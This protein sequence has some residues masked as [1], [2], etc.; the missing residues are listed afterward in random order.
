MSNIDL[1]Q[2]L[3]H[4]WQQGVEFWLE[5]DQLRFRGNKNL[6]SGDTLSL[7]RDNKPAITEIIKNNPQAYLGFPLSHGQRGIYLMQNLAPDSAAYNLTCLLQLDK[8]LNLT[9]LQNSL[10]FL[11][12][13]HAP[14]RMSIQTLDGYLAQ[15]VSYSLPSILT[16]TEVDKLDAEQLQQWV[17]E[18][19]DKAFNLA[20]EPLIRAR[21]LC[22]RDDH[23][24]RLLLVAHHIIADFWAM[25]LLVKELTAIYQ[26]GLTDS[27]P[28]LPDI[29]K[30]YKDFV[31]HERQWLDSEQGLAAKNYWNTKLQPLPATLELPTDYKRPQQQS[32][33]GTEFR[34]ELGTALTAQL[35]E[36][37][38][39]A[40]VTPF[41]WVLSVFQTLLH[42]YTGEDRI[43]VGSPMAC[44][45]QHDFQLLAGH[46][47]NPVIVLS[48]FG[49][50]TVFKEL[51]YDNKDQ[52][53]QAMK[54]QEYPL[55]CLMEDLQPHRDNPT[56][57]LFNAVLSWN[58]LN[59]TT[60][61][62]DFAPRQLVQEI[63]L[64]EQ[65]GAIYDLVLTGYD[66]GSNIELSWRFNTDLFKPGTI[67]RLSNH[68]L[69][70]L[71]ITCSNSNC[72]IG[73]LDFRTQQEK[74]FIVSLNDTHRD[75]ATH[76]S[77]AKLFRHTA[78]QYP[79]Y[80]ALKDGEKH[81]TYTE[82]ETRSNQLA[83]YLTSQGL[84]PR[85]HI[86]LCLYR[87]QDMLIAI[88]A[89]L[90]M[91]CTYIPIDTSYPNDRIAYMAMQSEAPLLI[92]SKTLT[93]KLSELAE[94]APHTAIQH[95]EDIHSVLDQY[96]TEFALYQDG[97]CDEDD[98]ACVLYTSGSTG[99]PKGVK[100]PHR[101]IIRLCT[102]T[103]LFTFK[104]ADKFC[105][106]SNI[107]FDATNIEIWGSFLNGGCLLKID[108]DTLLN[109]QRFS[110]FIERENPQA[111]L[112]TTAL[113]NVFISYKPDMFK[114]FNFIFV[115]GEALDI[116]PVRRCVEHGK[117]QHLLNIYGPTENGTIS[118]IY[119]IFDANIVDIPIGK[120]ISN[121][122]V[123]VHD[124]YGIPTPFN[125]QGEVFVGGE[126]I[127]TGY[128]KQPDL[129]AE[130]FTADPYRGKG[131]LYATG[132]LGYFREDGEL[133]YAGRRDDQV[134]IRGYRI[135]LGEIEQSLSQHPHINECCV[136]INK[137]AG[138]ATI[139]AYYSSDIELDSAAI[140]AFLRQTLPEFMIPSATLQMPAMPINPNGKVDKK[141]L[142]VIKLEKQADYTA[143]RNS[144]EQT[145]TT[146]WQAQLK[147][148]HISIFDNFFEI[149][150]HSLLAIKVAGALQDELHA[151]VTMRMLFEHPTIAGLAQ[152]IS[153]SHSDALPVI[154]VTA[155]KT[156]ILAA[157]SQQRLWFLQQ[158]NPAS[159]AYNMPV[160]L[161]IVKAIEAEQI[162]QCLKTLI[163]RHESLRTRFSDDNGIAYL[164]I[165]TLDDW[166]LPLVDL[167]HLS[168]TEAEQQAQQLLSQLAHHRFDLAHEL[169]F[170]SVLIRLSANEHILA[171]CLHHIIADG[172]SIDILLSELAQLW[173]HPAQDLP[174]LAINYSDFSAWQHQWLKGEKLNQQLLYWQ[175][176]LAG[177]PT[178]L[179]LPVDKPRPAVL[180]YAGAEFQFTIP[181]I[182]VNKL[183]ALSQ[184]NGATLFMTLLAGYSLLLSRYSQQNEICI[185][186]PI[187]GRTQKSMEPLVGLFVNNLIARCNLEQ[188]ISINDY[189]QQIKQTTINAY[190]H[191]DIPFDMIIDALKIER[192]LSYIPFLQASFSLE[193]SYFA[194]KIAHVMGADVRNQPLDW[195]VAKYDIHLSCFETS[196]SHLT[197]TIDYNTELFA[198][199]TIEKISRHYLALLNAI[200]E[201][202]ST[203]IDDVHF[204]SDLEYQQQ[205]DFSNGW[206][207][208]H[209]EYP[210]TESLHELF[211]AQASAT[212]N[213]IA[214][215]DDHEQ[216][217]YQQ[218]NAAANQLAHHL[219]S[220]GVTR[221]QP[222]AV[223]LDRSVHL[224]IALLAIL[225][226]GGAYVPLTTD[227]P[228]N[229]IAFICNDT[230]AR[231]FISSKHLELP[232]LDVT[233][234]RIHIED[235][236]LW[237]QQPLTN[238]VV[239]TQKDDLFNIIYTSGSTGNPKG[240]MVPHR[241]IINRLRWM[242]HA[243]P[244]GLQD[245]VLQK[246]PF[247]FD[248]SVW[249]LF[250]PLLQGSELVFAKPE[251]HKDPEYLRDMIRQ[252]GIT[253][254]HFVP[255]MLG[256]FLQTTDIQQCTS[257][258]Q[259]FASGE[260]LQLNHSETFFQ[261]LPQAG[262]FNLYGPTEASIDVS[263]YNCSPA[264]THSSIAIGKPIHNT[265]LHI[266]DKRL[267]ILPIGVA[268]DLYIGGEGLASGYWNQQELTRSTFIDNPWYAKGHPSKH[269]YKTGDV[270]RYRSDGNIEYLG[271]SD[272]QI[273][274][275]GLRVELGE[276]EA[277]LGKLPGIKE[278]TVILKATD[279]ANQ[280]LIA[281]LLSDNTEIDTALLTQSLKSILPEYMIPSA[282]VVLPEWPLS[283]NGKI[284]RKRLPEPALNFVDHY[285][286]AR[287]DTEQTLV[288]I[289]STLLRVEKIGIHDNFFELGG[290]SLLAT[291]MASRIRTALAC[292]LELKAIFEHPTIAELA[293]HLLE[294]EVQA[295]DIDE[296]ALLALLNELGD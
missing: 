145:I 186:F 281:Y 211:E 270:A 107:S 226:A 203:L 150:G 105:Y 287:N 123:Y 199:D 129:T 9:V 14:L 37:A 74:D 229:R 134:K 117:P 49:K 207:A 38:K 227:I 271:R 261:R 132:D 173:Q 89:S 275:R 256:A 86:A 167:S 228:A 138:I 233:A 118:T 206:N 260:A 219:I 62:N 33:K 43:T 4:L 143:P 191:Q 69:L 188:N 28:A 163:M 216:L 75:I 279:P 244:I 34:F 147:Q 60:R 213:A 277:A 230:R 64:T 80:I 36:Q 296:A 149:G 79:D 108:N 235:N 11:L 1:S 284:D 96:S 249:E 204:L 252:H 175:Q 103:N 97:Y 157:L 222:V 68:F 185:G 56:A 19:A 121:S 65:R 217:S 83:N 210:P 87:S 201:S 292:S 183:K 258:K 224:S 71:E 181:A 24:Y 53:L 113:F 58:Q 198:A 17:N 288:D 197:A 154:N 177:A 51:I 12:Q 70:L 50:T 164:Q 264:E 212:P 125:V 140:K 59:D 208:T 7:L 128:L 294:Q 104:P 278:C 171:F 272:H 16:V 289:W 93:E 200:A 282:F 165:H 35:K 91:G 26:A 268:G 214:L 54:Y 133:M 253:T 122:Q 46:F 41:I 155:D 247:N 85:D 239:G 162:D 90:K 262:L 148:D 151:E 273:K 67:E 158:L 27:T 115:G 22:N 32:F 144:T 189:I 5:G 280:R 45:M 187:A 81:Y 139:H 194:D 2:F 169:L 39:N 257:L 131:L 293:V 126:G 190:A 8:N 225:K 250:W 218:L 146:I 153:E 3:R 269:L 135:E 255:S 193:N 251:G 156:R 124:K 31:V 109:P 21:L 220:L 29:G 92:S 137:D 152:V 102:N 209:F 195:H 52:L 168:S 161:R 10:D 246:T 61:D 95:M 202:P 290:H 116:N 243:Y 223:C 295:L 88:L 111:A 172:L 119:D 176:Q 136:L 184:H 112:I 77:L 15:Q 274:I 73:Q 196:N 78:R 76:E 23:S 82:L 241:G 174:A 40:H 180:G 84:K 106:L 42:R 57:P 248:V 267:N 266:L 245:K 283:A 265:Q 170:R 276:I 130:K 221:N 6:V 160:A 236:N 192:S 72:I 44:R 182:T 127:S 242:Q 142:P 25:D 18:E 63:L 179:N 285:E 13:R 66:K 291:Q 100:T 114:G 30:L 120:P 47:T 205:M 215:V 55:Q 263:Y 159:T 286:A 178:L 110:D 240:V 166:A 238:P 98:I 259:V 99:K 20:N 234:T 94:Q 48:D 231:V 232:D 101:A 141:A 237:Q 254:L